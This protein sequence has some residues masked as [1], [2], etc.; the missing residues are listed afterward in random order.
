MAQGFSTPL[1]ERLTANSTTWILARAIKRRRRRRRRKLISPSI[2]AVRCQD[3]GD[4]AAAGGL[5]MAEFLR[6]KLSDRCLLERYYR[7]QFETCNE[8]KAE[9]KVIS[10]SSCPEVSVQQP[11]FLFDVTCARPQRFQDDRSFGLSRSASADLFN[12]CS[13]R[14]SFTLLVQLYP[15]KGGSSPDAGLSS[16]L[17]VCRGLLAVLCNQMRIAR[18][19]CYLFCN[20]TVFCVW[21]IL[22]CLHQVCQ[23]RAA[24]S[25]ALL[26]LL[27]G[28]SDPCNL[29]FANMHLMS[30]SPIL[31]NLG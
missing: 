15:F 23:D 4:C 30:L 8:H 3:L 21:W 16:H 2:S 20:F 6:F 1:C 22:F 5:G 28:S 18:Y 9:I 31:C 11:G 10:L 14:L 29:L 26:V 7:A 27:A 19:I 12:L 13:L 17:I 24:V 25:G